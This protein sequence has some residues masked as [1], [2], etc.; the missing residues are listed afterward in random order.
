MCL[1]KD[2]SSHLWKKVGLQLK[3]GLQKNKITIE[4]PFLNSYI[5]SDKIKKFHN[6]GYWF[7]I[8]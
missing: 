6:K 4:E 3:V 5:S 8:V 2:H 7:I 1:A